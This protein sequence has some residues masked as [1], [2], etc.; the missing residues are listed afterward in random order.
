MLSDVPLPPARVLT[1][2][3]TRLNAVGYYVKHS[4]DVASVVMSFNE[5]ESCTIKECQELLNRYDLKISLT[6][7]ESSFSII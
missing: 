2:W 6:S 1:R 5:E 4:E 7:I 3:G